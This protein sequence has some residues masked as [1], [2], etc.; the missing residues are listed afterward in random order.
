MCQAIGL[1]ETLLAI[2]QRC[3]LRYTI[4]SASPQTFIVWFGSTALSLSSLMLSLTS[5]M[6]VRMTDS[7]VFSRGSEAVLSSCG[8]D[9]RTVA[10]L[11]GRFGDNSGFLK[12]VYD[13][14]ETQ[15][16][17]ISLYSELSVANRDGIPK[18]GQKPFWLLGISLPASE[19]P[20][21]TFTGRNCSASP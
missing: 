12:M 2:S 10:I 8:R 21:L 19:A 3:S 5:L 18:R 11:L 6:W 4:V 14:F 7:R 17:I 15:L 20:S 9:E 1:A 16:R 13:P